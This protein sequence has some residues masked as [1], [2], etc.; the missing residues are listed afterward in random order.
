M[1][2]V[3]MDKLESAIRLAA[4]LYD[5]LDRRDYKGIASLLGED[6]RIEPATDVGTG[7]KETILG[8]EAGREYFEALLAGHPG[9]TVRCEEL[10]GFGHRC[11][12]RWKITGVDDDG[13]ES[14]L[15][16]VDIIREKDEKIR[17]ILTYIKV[18]E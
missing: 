3:R 14:N 7:S 4:A 2:P 18:A 9:A 5:T 8:A 12:V 6:C 17:E 11:V 10:I 13:G 16:G 15:R 1:S